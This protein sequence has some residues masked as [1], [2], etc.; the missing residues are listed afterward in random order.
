MIR[1]IDFMKN[2]F[3]FALIIFSMLFIIPTV[4]LNYLEK[5]I[6]N[7]NVQVSE[8]TTSETPEKTTDTQPIQINESEPDLIKVYNIKMEVGYGFTTKVR[9]F[10]GQRMANLCL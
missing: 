6:G 2:S 7:T 4:T 9:L 10:L 1:E 5:K 3:I 8:D